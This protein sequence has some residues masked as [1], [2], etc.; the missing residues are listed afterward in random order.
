MKTKY[1]TGLILYEMSKHNQIDKEILKSFLEKRDEKMNSHKRISNEIESRLYGKPLNKRTRRQ[2]EN[3]VEFI[4]LLI[5]IKTTC[6]GNENY[7]T[8]LVDEYFLQFMQKEISAREFGQYIKL[9][10]QIEQRVL[11]GDSLTKILKRM[12][13]DTIEEIE[14][15][16]KFYDLAAMHKLITQKEY[17]D[18]CLKIERRK[19]QLYFSEE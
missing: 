19:N 17:D 1:S 4:D 5:R 18:L 2:S 14:S 9:L 8:A 10:N 3:K 16:Q 15:D 12:G 7:L 11:N 6:I 13:L